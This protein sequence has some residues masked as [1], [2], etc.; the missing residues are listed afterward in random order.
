[1]D[2]EDRKILGGKRGKGTLSGG[3]FRQ[4]GNLR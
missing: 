1:M 4:K 3:R 2:S